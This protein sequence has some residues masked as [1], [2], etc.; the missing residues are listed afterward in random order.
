MATMAWI[1]ND[2]SI[3][4]LLAVLPFLPSKSPLQDTLDHLQLLPFY[5]TRTPL[6]QTAENYY[7]EGIQE[8]AMATPAEFDFAP[9]DI[10]MEMFA[11][12]YKKEDIFF[13]DDQGQRCI[14]RETLD[15]YQKKQWKGD[16]G[17]QRV[18]PRNA[19]NRHFYL[20]RYKK[21]L[22]QIDKPKAGGEIFA[23]CS[24]HQWNLPVGHER[25][26]LSF[27]REI[28]HLILEYSLTL[29]PE[30]LCLQPMMITC[31]WKREWNEEHYNIMTYENDGF[32]VRKLPEAHEE[33]RSENIRSDL[34]G[35]YIEF[36]DVRR[37]SIDAACLRVCKAFHAGTQ[38]LYGGNR[39]VFK[40]LA[41]M[42]GCPPSTLYFKATKQWRPCPAKPPFDSRLPRKLN[43]VKQIIQQHLPLQKMPGWMAYD[44]FLRFLWSIS[45]AKAALLRHLDFTG[46]VKL[47][48]CAR[49]ACRCDH[50]LQDSLRL[51]IPFIVHFCPK[52]ESIKIFAFE[53]RSGMVERQT[54]PGSRAPTL[55]EALLPI[56]ETDIRQIP[57]LR[58]LNVVSAA[59]NYDTS[60]YDYS[61]LGCAEPTRRWLRA[62]TRRERREAH[63]VMV[64]RARDAIMANSKTVTGGS[65]QVSIGGGRDEVPGKCDGARSTLGCG[66]CGGKGHVWANCY[67]LCACGEYGH[68][69][70]RCRGRK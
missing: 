48:Q 57:R 63:A 38:F 47:H 53:D 7:L 43:V 23:H 59:Y 49:G 44:P 32:E 3:D 36:R 58:E 21:T 60:C 67:N 42:G 55:A 35:A 12:K 56:L 62:R 64:A 70:G 13:L 46:D 16:R 10:A 27:P 34:D 6:R 69:R 22:K 18:S 17:L 24:E 25:H 45:P 39:F 9:E 29:K 54:E 11:R 2:T 26:V 8:W 19:K 14:I 15:Y 50:G 30:R 51:Y 28:L 5:P 40:M 1:P 61:P 65:G 33:F 37:A 4:S 66:F 20:R 41:P 68:L 31:N 52:V